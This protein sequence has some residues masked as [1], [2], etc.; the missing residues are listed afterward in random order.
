[1]LINWF[2]GLTCANTDDPL[3]LKFG[4]R[5]DTKF[6]ALK[7]ACTHGH[8]GMCQFLQEWISMPRTNAFLTLVRT[9][10]NYALRCAAKHG[11]L[12]VCRFFKNLVDR[13]GSRLQAH[14]LRDNWP[15]NPPKTQTYGR[16]TMLPFR[17]VNDSVDTDCASE[18][19]RWTGHTHVY[20]FLKAWEDEATHVS[21][22][23]TLVT[24]S[25]AMLPWIALM[26][27]IN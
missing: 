16:Y 1:M 11:H 19:A 14:D 10:Y 4:T 21:A 3:F 25:Y 15:W 2:R 20:L 23:S 26:V 8:V 12:E 24:L 13:D 22:Q 17:Y 7:W 18:L 27:L 9:N 6:N 5:F